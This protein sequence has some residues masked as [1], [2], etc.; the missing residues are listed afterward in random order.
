[1]LSIYIWLTLELLQDTWS[2]VCAHIS[3][4]VIIHVCDTTPTPTYSSYLSA[5]SC[6][7]HTHAHAQSSLYNDRLE[8]TG[9]LLQG[10]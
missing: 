8:Q 9:T 6:D 2:L 3:Y 1:M 5:L 4:Q 10:L 7:I